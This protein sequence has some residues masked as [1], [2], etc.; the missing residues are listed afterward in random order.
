PVLADE[1]RIDGDGAAPFAAP[2]G[3]T[4]A[5]GDVCLGVELTRTALVAPIAESGASGDTPATSWI[6]GTTVTLSVS[7]TSDASL[8][9]TLPATPD[10]QLVLPATWNQIS[11][12]AIAGYVESTVTFTPG[13]LGGYSGQVLY[14]A[15]GA[16]V[17]PGRTHTD[18]TP[19]N[20]TAYVLDCPL[21]TITTPA[22]DATYLLDSGVAAD[23]SC[24]STSS[25][26]SCAGPVPD[27]DSLDTS[28][29]GTKTFT[30]DAENAAGLPATRTVTYRVVYPFE[31]VAP[32]VESPGANHLTA[33]MKRTIRFSMDGYSG[34]EVIQG[35][36]RHR[37]V[38][39]E[40]GE[41]LGRLTVGRI[42]NFRYE[43]SSDQYVLLWKTAPGWDDTCRD[44][45]VRL[46]DGTQHVARFAFDL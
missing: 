15:T 42:Y 9:A 31:F 18:I 28:T 26:V 35:W 40:T 44:F 34:T 43:V 33:G 2:N 39:C 13:T 22:Q 20:V 29:V 3:Q 30:V 36:P 6:N 10:N 1:V 8:S 7:G 4:M 46:R 21:I 12:S 16:S 27:G 41:A 14:S 17:L 24:S 19:M 25:I 32:T 37:P 23:Y 45:V 38:D 5:L 11:G